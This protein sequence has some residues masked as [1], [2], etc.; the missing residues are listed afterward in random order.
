MTPQEFI[1][2]HY[3][4]PDLRVID[5]AIE[6]IRRGR[7]PY[8]CVALARAVQAHINYACRCHRDGALG[9]YVAVSALYRRQYK[10]FVLSKNAGRLPTFW[11]AAVTPENH[12]ARIRA[13]QDFRAACIA[14]A[15]KE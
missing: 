9:A 13:L 7:C 8:S 5:R 12:T 1:D 11:D 14:A 6:G 10:E 3:A 4:A 15:N 2:K